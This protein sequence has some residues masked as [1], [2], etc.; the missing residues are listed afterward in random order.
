MSSVLWNPGIFVAGHGVEC[1]EEFAGDGDDDDLFRVVPDEF[2]GQLGECFWRSRPTAAC[3]FF[4]IENEEIDDV[5]GPIDADDNGCRISM[6]T[7]R[8]SPSRS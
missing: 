1:D 3:F 8:A 2:G 7:R 6:H 5:L 4:S